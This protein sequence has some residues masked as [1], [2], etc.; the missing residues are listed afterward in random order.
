MRRFRL[1]LLG[2]I[3]LMSALLPAVAA[4]SDASIRFVK[5]GDRRNVGLGEV[6][7]TVD[8]S[9]VSL[10]D[11]YRWQVLIDGVPE[12]IVADG[13]TTQVEIPK[14]SGPHRLMAVL[15]DPQGSRIASDEILVIAAPVDRHDPV[16]N[17][18]WFAPLMAVFTLVIIGI[19]ILGLRLR[20]RLAA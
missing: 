1:V 20:P 8:I 15:L 11:G 18:E 12:P 2:V 19:I 13:L 17:R 14:P 3:G 5:P 6:S 4:Q 9:G 16:F 10:N 7:V